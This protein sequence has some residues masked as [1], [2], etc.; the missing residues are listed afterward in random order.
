LELECATLK[1]IPS[2]IIGSD[3]NFNAQAVS[4]NFSVTTYESFSTLSPVALDF[5]YTADIASN[6]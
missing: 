2:A 5:Y 4:N 1:E 6:F 3:E